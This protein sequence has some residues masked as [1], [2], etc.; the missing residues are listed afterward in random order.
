MSE[1]YN[2]PGGA[3]FQRDIE[4]LHERCRDLQVS[5]S[6]NYD[7]AEDSW[8]ISISSAAP[9]ECFIGKNH[10]LWIAMLSTFEFL[11]T[12]K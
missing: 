8:Y 2:K 3:A 10:S 6:L 4:K 1:C 7:E 9:V 12:L 5:Y 11:D